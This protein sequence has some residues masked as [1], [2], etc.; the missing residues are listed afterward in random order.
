MGTME[1]ALAVWDAVKPYA[2][3]SAAGALIGLLLYC[4]VWG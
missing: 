3:V 2:L 1:L 4:V